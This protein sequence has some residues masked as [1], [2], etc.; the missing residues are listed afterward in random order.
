MLAGSYIG[1]NTI[2]I[3]ERV[4]APPGPGEVELAVAF[5]GICGTDLHVLH[6]AMD[7]RV[8]P[9]AVIGHEMSGTVTAFGSDVDGWAAG[10]RAVVMPLDWCG[11]CPACRAGNSHICQKLNFIGI[12]SPGSLQ[13]RWTVPA[14][15]L[16]R[17]PEKLSL[18]TAALT[19][20]TAV[21]VHDVRRA[22]LEAGEKVIV[23]GGGP[24]GLLIASVATTFGADVIVLEVNPGRRAIAEDLGL[25]ALDPVTTDVLAFVEDWTGGAGAAIS[26]EVSASEAGF[27]TA[28]SCL[29]VRGRLVVVAIHSTPKPIDLQRVFWRELT[30]HGAR[31]YQQ[32]DFEAALDILA[33]GRVDVERL[34]TRVLPLEQVASAFDLLDSGRAMKVLVDCRAERGQG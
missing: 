8:K 15:V 6:G 23:V 5:T 9:P 16:V 4:A 24:I 31:V 10:D 13:E 30:L 19:E 25:R 32:R 27:G 2:T 21:A 22:G 34:I 29:A 14:R 28:V 12:D 18:K 11:S 20:P 3:S 7:K 17:V 26:F 33:E 1:H